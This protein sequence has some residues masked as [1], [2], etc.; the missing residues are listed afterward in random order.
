[1][2]TR[3][4]NWYASR[5]K[6]KISGQT[7]APGNKFTL[8][9]NHTQSYIKYQISTIN[10]TNQK[11]KVGWCLA[12]ED[13]WSSYQRP[14]IRWCSG[15]NSISIKLIA[16]NFEYAHSSANRSSPTAVMAVSH[17]DQPKLTPILL[18]LL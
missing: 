17:I 13:E 15:S 6:N 18:R 16:D 12:W 10:G 4:P 1:M 8:I 9:S 7:T 3:L 14:R 2:R 5:D 11:H